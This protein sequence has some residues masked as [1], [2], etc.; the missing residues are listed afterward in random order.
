MRALEGTG[1]D[2]VREKDRHYSWRAYQVRECVDG[3][4]PIVGPHVEGCKVLVAGLVVE[5][6]LKAERRS[7]AFD[8]Q[9]RVKFPDV[10]DALGFKLAARRTWASVAWVLASHYGCEKTVDWNR[11]GAKA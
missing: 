10:C 7:F 2:L 11:K 4:N 5:C 6:D 1:G 3:H 9:T 8:A